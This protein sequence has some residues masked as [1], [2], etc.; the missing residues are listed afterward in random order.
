[1]SRRRLTNNPTPQARLPSVHRSPA[2]SAPPLHACP[3]N[4]ARSEI[5]AHRSDH[6][7]ANGFFSAQPVRQAKEARSYFRAGQDQERGCANLVSGNV[8]WV[9]RTS[10]TSHDQAILVDQATDASL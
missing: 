2:A 5:L 1:R 8:L 10:S 3:A 6:R 7:R 9:P 4:T